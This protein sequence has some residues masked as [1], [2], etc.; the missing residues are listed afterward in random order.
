[1]PV[2]Y[3]LKMMSAVRRCSREAEALAASAIAAL[4]ISGSF[5]RWAQ[6]RMLSA[7]AESLKLPGVLNKVAR[8]GPNAPGHQ[9]SIGSVSGWAGLERA[10]AVIRVHSASV[11][12]WARRWSGREVT[13]RVTSARTLNRVTP[14][15]R[16]PRVGR[17][18]SARLLSP[19]HPIPSRLAPVDRHA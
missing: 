7:A 10:L 1:P 19:T 5:R 9:R 16:G 4:K 11:G 13:T 15:V 8:V 6:R 12:A 18:I 3:F 17:G 2:R 14:R